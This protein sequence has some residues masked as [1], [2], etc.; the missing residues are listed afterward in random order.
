MFVL[1]NLGHR[2]A[3]NVIF[4]PFFQKKFKPSVGQEI[5]A[6]SKIPLQVRL[7]LAASLS[8]AEGGLKPSIP[9]L[10]SPKNRRNF[11][12]NAVPDSCSSALRCC[13]PLPSQAIAQHDAGKYSGGKVLSSFSPK[14]KKRISTF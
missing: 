4:W 7:V 5:D 9:G 3:L 14:K 12:A 10:I 13:S 11:A 2:Q 8:H 1:R 6:R